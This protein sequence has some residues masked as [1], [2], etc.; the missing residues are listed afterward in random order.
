MGGFGQ[1]RRQSYVDLE[2]ALVVND[3]D[4]V[5]EGVSGDSGSTKNAKKV[6]SFFAPDLNQRRVQA[7][8]S[9][10]ELGQISPVPAVI[11]EDTRG[12][13]HERL[14]IGQYPISIKFLMWQDSNIGNYIEFKIQVTYHEGHENAG[15]RQSL[16]SPHASANLDSVGSNS[17]VVYKRYS[18]FVDLHEILVPFYKAE[19][20]QAP[21][22]PPKIANEAN[23]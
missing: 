12:E 6:H 11:V 15:Q 22:L 17:W 19:G 2:R 23:S 16:I 10:A 20:V 5:E 9:A 14:R 3:S 13:L 21:A 1:Y 7:S 8:N 18:N 4:I